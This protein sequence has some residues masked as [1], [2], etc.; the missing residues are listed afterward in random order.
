M[1]FLKTFFIDNFSNIIWIAVFI[2]CLLPVF[3][4][5]IAFPFAINEKLLGVNKMSPVLAIVTC[6]LA[7]IFLTLFLL[8]FFKSFK[9]FLR[10][11]NL[12]EKIFSKLDILIEKKSVNIK[13]KNNKYLYLSLFVLIPLPLTGVWSGS[14][15]ASFLN[16]DFKKSLIAIVAGNLLC[17]ILIFILNLFLK[18]FTIVLL[19]I[20]FLITFCVLFIQKIKKIKFKIKFLND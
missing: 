11:F 19:I 10:R 7:S 5:R 4:G 15:I 2:M 18:D 16:L 3:E 8:V 6:F 12:F 9:K 13:N 14:L 17:L 20:S 1:E